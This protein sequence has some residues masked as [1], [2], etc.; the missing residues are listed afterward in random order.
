MESEDIKGQVEDRVRGFIETHG[1]ERDPRPLVL[2]VSG[3]PDSICLL[4]A[5]AHLKDRLGLLLHVAHLNHCLRGRESDEDA[6]Y[7]AQISKSLGL[8]C[9]VCKEDV[10]S[11]RSTHSHSLEERARESRY[12]FLVRVCS[13]VV[14]A[15]V[16]VG[17]TADDQAETILLHLVRGS[18]L[19]GLRGMRPVTILEAPATSNIKLF[20][21][22]LD[23]HRSDT[24]RYCQ[25]LDITPRVDRSNLSTRHLRNKVRLELR[26]HLREYNPNVDAALRRLAYSASLDMDFI[27]DEVGK[28]WESVVAEESDGL[29]VNAA[30]LSALAPSLRSHL[31]RRSIQFVVGNLVDIEQVHILDLEEL[32]SKPTGKSLHLP[33]GAVATM[34]YGQCVLTRET[35]RDE[36]YTPFPNDEPLKIPGV[37]EM[38][39]WVVRASIVEAGSYGEEPNG[40]KAAL[41]LNAVGTQLTVRSRCPGDRFQPLGMEQPKKLQDFLVNSK[42]P[43]RTREEIPLVYAQGRIVWVAGWRIDEKSK[44]TDATTKVLLLEFE[45]QGESES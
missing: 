36:E 7:V 16:A 17:H 26:P 45:K 19:A 30:R 11:R 25:A 28:A 27:E 42:V 32:L 15:G 34:E 21:P 41:D 22:L 9:T 4:Y 1:L 8:P 43:R 2:G 12:E 14:G 24:E 40:L 3:G 38:N 5:L 23:V 37:T 31:L 29:R 39:G 18:G 10:T 35:I 33:R 6:E 20:R 44:V 13:D